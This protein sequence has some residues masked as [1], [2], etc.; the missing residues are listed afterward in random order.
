[1]T[2]NIYSEKAMKLKYKATCLTDVLSYIERKIDEVSYT[3]GP[4]GEQEQ[5]YEWVDRKREYKFD[6]DGNPIMK[7][8]WGDVPKRELDEMDKATISAYQEIAETICKTMS[9]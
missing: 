2:N 6:D 7:D 8:V 4:T 3:Y 1:M 9:K 5:D